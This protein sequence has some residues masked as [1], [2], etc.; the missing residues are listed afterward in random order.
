MHGKSSDRSAVLLLLLPLILSAAI[1]SSPCRALAAGDENPQENIAESQSYGL[2]SAVFSSSGKS[3]VSAS[4][5]MNST[6]G[7]SHPVGPVTG[8]PYNLHAGFWNW[9]AWVT[10]AGETPLAFRLSQNYPN[11]FNPVTTIDY[12]ISQKTPVD[13]TIYD[14]TG[15]RVR[16][17]VREKQFPGGYS[18]TW[19]GR[20]DGGRP[21]ATGV[22]FYRLIAGRNINVKK[23]VILR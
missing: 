1:L 18:V 9:K 22:Y 8:T 4:Y 16:S 10:D 11:P 17:L 20:N 6:L 5:F 14:V 19:D 12:S 7:Q 23:M 15:R 2:S 3:S 13:L 21:V